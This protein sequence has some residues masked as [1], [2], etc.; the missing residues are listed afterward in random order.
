MSDKKIP[1]LNENERKVLSALA[2]D[3]DDLEWRAWYFRGL[4][5][6]TKLNLSQVRRAC[7]SLAKKGLAKF[8]RGL[9]NEDGET[10]GSGYRATRL[11]AA[12]MNPCDIC[13][14]L[15]S[16]DYEI[17]ASGL[18]E[19]KVGFDEKTRRRIRECGS[20]YKQSAARPVPVP[21]SL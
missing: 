11:G 2:E 10:A 8:E 9:F 14:D 12:L 4:V 20:H 13:G 19:W 5:A 18:N 6:D 17:D 7:R 3:Y 1:T 16:Y 15:A 21:L